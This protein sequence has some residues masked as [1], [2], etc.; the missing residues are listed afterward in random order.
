[1][2]EYT[3]LLQDVKSLDRDSLLRLSGFLDGLL[4]E[5]GTA[6]I[7]SAAPATIAIEQKSVLVAF[8]SQSGNAENVALQL[9]EGLQSIPSCAVK[10]ADVAELNLKK[11]AQYAYVF[12]IASTHGEGEP[13][14]TA[15]QFYEQLKSNR[16]P[17]MDLVEYAIIALGD[18]S[19]DEFCAFGA[20]IDKRFAELGAK[21]IV[22]R[23][24]C[25]VDYEQE[26][27]KW[28]GE[29][30]D[31]LSKSAGAE[32]AINGSAN[33]LADGATKNYTAK[34]PLQVEVISNVNL[35]TDHASKL[36]HH[37]ELEMLS[38]E[39]SYLP[40]DSLGVSVSNPQSMVE[41]LLAVSQLSADGQVSFNNKQLSLLECLNNEAELFRITNKQLLS[42]VE[43][44]PNKKLQSAIANEAKISEFIFSQDWLS[45]LKHYDKLSF[46]KAQDLID[47]L[48]PQ[49]QRL[50]SISSSPLAHEDEVHL[51]IRLRE[52]GEEKH[53]GLISGEISRLEEG[54]RV[55]VYLKP[56]KNFR[57][58]EDTSSPII[59][60]G[61]G[62]GIAPF[63]A[64][65]YH[66]LELGITSPSWLFFGEQSFRNSFLY[67]SDWLKLLEKKALSELTVAFSRETENPRY[68]QDRVRE[69]AKEVYKWIN[70]GAYIY[71]CGSAEGMAPAVNSAL[72]DV[73]SEQSGVNEEAAKQRLQQLMIDGFYKRDVY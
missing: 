54:D 33:N 29:L 21:S 2:R 57:L 15:I 14:D 44:Y 50:Y 67:Q 7:A 69:N 60:I 64:F 28:Q 16:A 63:R 30:L 36:V 68:V 73:I 20:W 47:L 5:G 3:Q 65:L 31:V 59:M 39:I 49:G 40:G 6:T 66:R 51:S 53:L 43:N 27:E 61:S 10:V 72:V 56:N 11:I 4:L 62:T 70:E 13:P 22:S 24:D 41:E 37:V 18:S 8:A 45:L 71:V 38:N 32:V 12:V 48:N 1:M 58:P 46:S 55:N 34:N 52:F 17:Q 42:L 25:D 9:A 35:C 23:L 19:Y 26:V